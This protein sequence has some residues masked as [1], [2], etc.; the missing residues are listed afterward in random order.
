MIARFRSLGLFWVILMPYVNDSMA[1]TQD[2]YCGEMNCYEGK[3]FIQAVD[4]VSYNCPIILFLVL[5]VTRDSP[6]SEI[7]KSYRQ[8]AKLYHP[9]RHMKL[10][11][12]AEAEEVFKRV[13]TAY[14]LAS[15]NLGI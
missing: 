15:Y 12:K 4:L 5:K 9:D 13:A 1:M 14:V 3:S 8:L 2:L 10:E 6:R 7:A 11:A